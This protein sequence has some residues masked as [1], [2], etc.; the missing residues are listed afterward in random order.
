MH[1][2]VAVEMHLMARGAPSPQHVPS[3]PRD[4]GRRYVI[5]RERLAEPPSDSLQ[6]HDL[7]KA[8]D[9]AELGPDDA[10]TYTQS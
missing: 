3:I 2:S 7:V 8:P 10:A 6:N 1:S 5:S 4:S 9:E